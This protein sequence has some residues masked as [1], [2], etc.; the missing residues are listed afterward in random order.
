M[1]AYQRRNVCTPVLH[2]IFKLSGQS[3]Y[4]VAKL[5][6]VSTVHMSSPK[7][8]T[9]DALLASLAVAKA[10]PDFVPDFAADAVASFAVPRTPPPS[11]PRSSPRCPNAPRCTDSSAADQFL[12]RLDA[13]AGDYFLW[14]AKMKRPQ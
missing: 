8:V 7:A 12:A 4:D 11:S 2:V 1:F 3:G 6:Q 9:I 13:S 10:A 14:L 5:A